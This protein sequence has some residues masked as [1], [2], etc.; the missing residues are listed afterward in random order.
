[1]PGVTR[2]DREPDEPLSG[3]RWWMDSHPERLETTAYV[4]AERAGWTKEWRAVAV[5]GSGNEIRVT[6]WLGSRG[7]AESQVESLRR[8]RADAWLEQRTVS[9]PRPRPDQG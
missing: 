5:D 2:K 9:P 3:P 7:L 1:M 6:S 4:A 8:H